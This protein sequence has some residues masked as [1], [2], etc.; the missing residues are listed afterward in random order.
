VTSFRARAPHLTL[1]KSASTGLTS[2]TKSKTGAVIAITAAKSKAFEFQLWNQNI[3]PREP[4]F[5]SA[6]LQ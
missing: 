3:L 5:K 4:C 2:F 1:I 6:A